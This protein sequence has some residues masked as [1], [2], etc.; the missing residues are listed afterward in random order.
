MRFPL[1]IILTG[2]FAFSCI[3]KTPK[4]PVP[5]LEYK[6]FKAWKEGLRDT[7]VMTLTYVD[8]DGDLFRNATS[9]GPN[10]ILRTF[11]F[12]TD[13]N[14]FVKDQTLSYA[15]IQPGDGFYKGKSIQGDIIIPFGQF[16]PNNTVKQIRF[17]VF[18][19]DMKDNKSNVVSTP[20]F[21]LNF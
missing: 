4:D 5:G 6:D 21:S 16:R 12:N 8:N 10:T 18:M 20:Q 19:V 1:I 3:K 9:D 17:E 7:A 13:S 15:I 14:K 2:L 11:V